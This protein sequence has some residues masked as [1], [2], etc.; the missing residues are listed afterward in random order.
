LI[1][2]ELVVSHNLWLESDCNLK[3][4]GKSGFSHLGLKS[5]RLPSKVEFIGEHC[6]FECESLNEVIFEKFSM[7]TGTVEIENSAFALSPV[8]VVIHNLLRFRLKYSFNEGC[9][10]EYVAKIGIRGVGVHVWEVDGVEKRH[11]VEL[12]YER[13][14]VKRH[15][16]RFTVIV[17]QWRVFSG[18]FPQRLLGVENWAT[19]VIQWLNFNL[20]SGLWI[21]VRRHPLKSFCQNWNFNFAI[22]KRRSCLL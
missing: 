10:L 15:K 11:F 3:R 14:E 13:H 12:V 4:I 21:A 1:L 18:N 17:I 9:R 20:D 8:R 6:F 16:T 5:I 2:Y 22:W 7:R 19:Q